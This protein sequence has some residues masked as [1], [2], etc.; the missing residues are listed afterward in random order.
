MSYQDLNPIDKPFVLTTELL[1]FFVVLA[2]CT[3]A[4]LTGFVIYRRTSLKKSLANSKKIR[5]IIR[6]SP[7]DKEVMVEP[8]PTSD[9]SL[10]FEIDK[11]TDKKTGWKFS[12]PDGSV[13]LD[14]KGR[15]YVQVYYGATKAI[16]FNYTDQNTDQPHWN[17]EDSKKFITAQALLRRY[18][19]QAQEL[20]SMKTWIIII[21]VLVVGAIILGG[22]N[23]YLISKIPIA[24]PP[25]I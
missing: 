1:I 2:V 9:G 10:M 5:V 13:R 17:K 23:A 19:K 16:V 12:A 21:L 8:K 6:K 15:P 11:D 4:I 25:V 7:K 18:A 3:V 14:S 20:S 22:V 24:A